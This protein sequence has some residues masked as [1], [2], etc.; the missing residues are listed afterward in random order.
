LDR[1]YERL[2][3]KCLPVYTVPPVKDE[4]FWECEEIRQA[5][6][7]AVIRTQL[8]GAPPDHVEEHTI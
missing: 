2:R 4:T 3:D 1:V 8:L 5:Q 6:E 7:V